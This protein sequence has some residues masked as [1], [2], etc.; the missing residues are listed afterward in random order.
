MKDFNALEKSFIPFVRRVLWYRGFFFPLSIALSL[1]LEAS[2]SQPRRTCPCSVIRDSNKEYSRHV[3]HRVGR[4]AAGFGEFLSI[5]LIMLLILMIS[6]S[7]EEVSGSFLIKLGEFLITFG[8][9][10]SFLVFFFVEF[11]DFLIGLVDFPGGHSLMTK[12][13]EPH[14][15]ISR[16]CTSWCNTQWRRG[17]LASGV[18]FTLALTPLLREPL[19]N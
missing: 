9:F 7:T 11:G 1:G 3:R 17:C 19:T 14:R 12:W 4:T 8:G 18:S 16:V 5:L 2:R 10:S 6:S 15:Q 13:I